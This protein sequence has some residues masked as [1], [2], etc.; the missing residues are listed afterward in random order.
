MVRMMSPRIVSGGNPN[1]RATSLSGISRPPNSTST[2]FWTARFMRSIT[3]SDKSM[4]LI[5][6][7]NSC[8]RSVLVNVPPPSRQ[9]VQTDESRKDP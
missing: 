8:F 1:R 3:S 7:R 6:T 5:V 9:F 4:P 2:A